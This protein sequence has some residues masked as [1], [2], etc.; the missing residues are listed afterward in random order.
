MFSYGNVV[1]QK[2]LAKMANVYPSLKCQSLYSRVRNSIA[3]AQVYL[4]S[5]H[6]HASIC[7]NTLQDPGD[8]LCKNKTTGRRCDRCQD[9]YYN[10]TAENPE[11]CQ[12]NSLKIHLQIT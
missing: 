11:G 12:G 4:C 9:G 10:L 7:F 1:I 3:S 5:G 8:C 6:S 2:C